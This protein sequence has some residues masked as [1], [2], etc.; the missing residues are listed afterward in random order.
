MRMRIN[1]TISKKW[2]KVTKSAKKWL[3]R[4]KWLNWKKVT[5]SSKK[6]LKERL[7]PENVKTKN[8]KSAG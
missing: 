7:M 2:L 1:V 8:A 5:K 6:W 4:K 3:N